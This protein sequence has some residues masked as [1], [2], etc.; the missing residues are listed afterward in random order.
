M[1]CFVVSSAEFMR[2]DNWSVHFHYLLKAS[3]ERL[4]D[5]EEAFWKYMSEIKKLKRSDMYRL[6]RE[7]PTEQAV[8]DEIE[9]ILLPGNKGRKLTQ[10]DRSGIKETLRAVVETYVAKVNAEIA[11]N[12]AEISKVKVKF[13]GQQPAKSPVA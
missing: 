4:E 11:A 2:Y 10:E 12:I 6:L 9:T 1:K 13:D 7:L 8:I 3:R 5:R